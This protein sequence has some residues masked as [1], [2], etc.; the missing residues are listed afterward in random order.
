MNIRWLGT[1]LVVSLSLLASSPALAHPPR[2]NR[3]AVHVPPSFVPAQN[4]A[5][6]PKVAAALHQ[7]I[8]SNKLPPGYAVVVHDGHIV[9]AEGWGHHTGPGSGPANG[10]SLFHIGSIT[11]T[12]TALGILSLAEQHKLSLDDPL[13][14]W[15]PGVH[16]HLKLPRDRQPTIR[17]ALYHFSGLPDA[18][19]K[20]AAAQAGGRF[21]ITK[22]DIIESLNAATVSPGRKNVYSNIA[23]NAL[24]LVIEKASGENYY[25]YMKQHVFRPLGITDEAW[26]PS[27]VPQAQ[28]VYTHSGSPGHWVGVRDTYV[29]GA[30][31]PAGG[32]YLSGDDMLK[33]LRWELGVRPNGPLSERMRLLSQKPAESTLKPPGSGHIDRPVSNSGMGWDI[34]PDTHGND[35]LLK[36]GGLGNTNDHWS[37]LIGVRPS[38]HTATVLLVSGDGGGNYDEATALINAAQSG[39]P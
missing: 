11:K 27:Q 16:F 18:G 29:F 12:F 37:A 30:T 8:T 32:V 39:R 1:A 3:Q 36:N 38:S 31:D 23:F 13:E 33:L 15:I 4:E 35:T 19:S 20:V 10:N 17:D 26:K 21:T 7:V 24:G 5:R 2:Q 6:D 9:L 22:Q 25:A 14:R 34:A 28:L